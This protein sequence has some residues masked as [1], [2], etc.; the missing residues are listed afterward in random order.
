MRIVFSD[1]LI[2]ERY[3]GTSQK[4]NQYGRLQFLDGDCNVFTVFAG[5]PDSDKLTAFPEK[6]RVD[7]LPFDLLPARDGGVRLVPAW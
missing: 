3:S 2:L 5:G 6:S 4:G 1:C 7:S